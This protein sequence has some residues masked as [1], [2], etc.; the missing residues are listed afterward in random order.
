MNLKP[1]GANKTELTINEK[2][3]VIKVLFSYE[4]PVAYSKE[5]KDG[6]AIYRRTKQFYSKTTTRHINSWLPSNHM[7]VEQSEI[8]GLVK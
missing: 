2:D 1:L 7:E 5:Y 3:V 4:T 8:D 6:G